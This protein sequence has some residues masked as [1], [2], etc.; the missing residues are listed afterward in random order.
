MFGGKRF[1]IHHRNDGIE[2]SEIPQLGPQKCQDNRQWIGNAG[3][4]NHHVIDSVV[5]FE[6][7]IYSIDQVIINGAT[8]TTIAK[9]EHIRVH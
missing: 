5:P 9:L 6:N 2:A 3:S 1:G 8:N 4:L 7:A